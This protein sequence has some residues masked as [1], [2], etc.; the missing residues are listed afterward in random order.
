M[1]TKTSLSFLSS[2]DLRVAR[3]M[4][5]LYWKRRT[6]PSAST[7]AFGSLIKTISMHVGWRALS[8]QMSAGFPFTEGWTKGP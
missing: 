7:V 6:A 8:W 5:G 4:D 2:R 1:F 3:K